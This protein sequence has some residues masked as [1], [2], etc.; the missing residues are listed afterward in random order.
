MGHAEL[1]PLDAWRMRATDRARELART[2]AFV[3]MWRTL[4]LALHDLGE[5]YLKL[6]SEQV[7]RFLAD[8]LDAEPPDGT[9]AVPNVATSARRPGSPCSTLCS[10]QQGRKHSPEVGWRPR[11]DFVGIT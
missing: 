1:G 9:A 8:L 10:L 3:A 2:R 6:L 11:R 5:Q 4:V 7:D